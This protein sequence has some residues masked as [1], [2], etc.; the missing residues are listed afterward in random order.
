MVFIKVSIGSLVNLGLLDL[1]VKYRPRTLYLLQ[2]SPNGCLAKCSFCAQSSSS[3]L[4]KK[5]LSRTSW[6][7]YNILDLTDRLRERK[8]LFVRICIQ[9][10]IKDGFE[11]E[12]VGLVYTLRSFG[13]E[14]N[15]SV[16]LTPVEVG[17]LNALRD[18]DVDYVGVGLDTFTEKLFV[19][20][21]KPHG[22]GKYMDFI[23]NCKNVFGSKNVVV[24]LIVGLGE[25]P[26]E[27]VETISR[28]VKEGLSI[29]LFPYVNPR[30]LRPE[31][32]IEYYRFLQ[33]YT[34][35]VERGGEC[36]F[37]EILRFLDKIIEDPDEYYSIFLTKGCPGCDRPYYT[38]SPRGPFYNLYGYRHY[39]EY[40]GFLTKELALTKQFIEALLK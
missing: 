39:A 16:C 10:I 6:Y 11:D 32:P 37:D 19:E 18:L 38:E 35:V 17:V 13:V 2:Y 15:I 28:F 4:D 20:M 9:S 21:K 12:L 26:G 29:A 5:F 27:A 33:I 34:H 30:S 8:G 36:G 25:K 1:N 24:H 40:K 22:W 14:T 31:V 7:P 23:A 3:G